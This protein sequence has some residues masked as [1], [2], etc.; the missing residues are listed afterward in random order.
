[1]CFFPS[2]SMSHFENKY[3]LQ[4]KSVKSNKSHEKLQFFFL[5]VQYD[6]VILLLN[7]R[8]ALY[9]SY[10]NRNNIPVNNFPIMSSFCLLSGYLKV[11]FFFTMHGKHKMYFIKLDLLTF[12]RFA[13]C[14]GFC[15]VSIISFT[16][17]MAVAACCKMS[18]PE[19]YAAGYT[20]T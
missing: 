17:I 1:M 7:Q 11:S 3:I 8:N 6:V 16:A 15:W 12:A 10:G 2:N 20:T 18:A 9:R 14:D 13:M 5:L 4:D 19:T